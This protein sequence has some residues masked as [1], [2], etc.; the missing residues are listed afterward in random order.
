MGEYLMKSH[1]CSGPNGLPC[2]RMPILARALGNRTDFSAISEIFHATASGGSSH[3]PGQG[4]KSFW[5]ELCIRAISPKSMPCMRL[6]RTSCWALPCDCEV[7]P[8]SKFLPR[9]NYPQGDCP[10]ARQTWKL[11]SLVCTCNCPAPASVYERETSRKVW[12]FNSMGPK[13][14]QLA[15]ISAQTNNQS[16]LPQL[17][18]SLSDCF[19]PG[20]ESCY[21]RSR[22]NPW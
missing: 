9:P 5:Q 13:Q 22:K 4:L 3:S 11:G 8:E 14:I 18:I 6:R 20:R 1:G 10:N 15:S 19:S 2:A 12:R 17:Y 21:E 7:A 16:L